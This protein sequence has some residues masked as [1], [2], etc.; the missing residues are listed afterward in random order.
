MQLTSSAFQHEGRIPAKFTCDGENQS[1]DF[2]WSDAPAQTKSFALIM[3]DPDAPR[4]DGFT[5]WVMYDI[6][7]DTG[8]LSPNVPNQERVAGTG[9]QG[10]N[11]TGKIGYMGPCPPS[12]T[13]RY[14]VRLY[15]L[16][17]E[18]TL[19]PGATREQVEQAIQGHV[20]D[21]AELMGTYARRSERA[22]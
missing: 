1:P 17:R 7:A 2:S 3:H 11:D 6:P 12:G 16:D 22:A 15:A 9:I 10:K 21:Q 18:L 19:N 14:F 13:H 5:H 4:A 20:L 8:A